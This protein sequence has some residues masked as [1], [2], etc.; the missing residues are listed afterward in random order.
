V[1]GIARVRALGLDAMELQFVQRVS[2]G[3]ET[4]RRVWETARDNG[5]RLSAHAP[6]YINFNS[7]EREKVE[8]SRER[9]L[10]A[11]RVAALCGAHSVV[12]HAAYYHDDAPSVVYERVKSRL[13]EIVGQL[14]NEAVDVC[15]RPETSGRP[16]QFGSLQEV[17]RLS[18]EVD[19]LS[20]C[21]DFGHLY[22]RS[23]GAINAHAE[24]GLVMQ[25]IGEALGSSALREMHMHVQ[26]M[27]YSHAG[28]RKHLTLAAS[29]MRYEQLLRALVDWGVGGTVICESPSLEEDAVLLQRTYHRL[30]AARSEA[31]VGTGA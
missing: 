26:G 5:V 24:F 21:I 16:S 13:Q 27:E 15:L 3:P 17:L 9:L 4:A 7:K 19:G 29:D 31:R 30:V 23:V 28:E 10:H 18:A 8:A 25:S 20:P 22:A 14:R 6:Y 12:F 1:A 11:A 2:M